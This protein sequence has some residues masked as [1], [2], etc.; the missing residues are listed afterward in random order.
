LRDRA[1]FTWQ[2]WNDAATYLLQQNRDLDLAL[3]WSENAVA[4]PSI[5]EANFA[6]LSTKA[7]ILE[8]LSRADEAK[9]IMATALDLPRTS[10][11]EIHQY[12]RQLLAQG[13]KA[14]ALAVFQKNQKRYGDAWPVHVG[15][16]RGYSAL[17]DYKV[18]L[19][20]AQKALGQAPDKLNKDNLATAVE[21]LKQ[22][23]DMNVGS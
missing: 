12:G 16:A 18:A 20:H 15:L 7:Q 9:A 2:G 22:G 14:D 21:K 13:R 6:T 1:G 11:L 19:E 17:G 3:K 23:K 8:K 4:M 5:G 10:A